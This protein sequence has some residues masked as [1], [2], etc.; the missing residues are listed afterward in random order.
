[1]RKISS[2]LS[3]R[4]FRSGL[5][6]DSTLNAWGTARDTMNKKTELSPVDRTKREIVRLMDEEKLSVYDAAKKLGI[7]REQVIHW[8]LKDK[9]FGLMIRASGMVKMIEM[10]EKA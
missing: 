10:A 3:K 7:V 4:K 6:T 1:R 8:R 2:K 9:E 5:S